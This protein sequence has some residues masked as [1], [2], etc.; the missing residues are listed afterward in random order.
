MHADPEDKAK[1]VMTTDHYF[2][3]A[4][5]EGISTRIR[6]GQPLHFDQKQVEQF[7]TTLAKVNP[8]K[9]VRLFVYGLF[10]IIVAVIIGAIYL[11]GRFFLR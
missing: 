9:N 6:S 11:I 10:A 8:E 7:A 5:L 2:S 4:D 3:K 1:H